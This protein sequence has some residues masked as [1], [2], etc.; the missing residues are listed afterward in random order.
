MN[1]LF[2]W[3][4][5]PQP[6]ARLAAIRI[7]APLAML[8]F[9]SSRLAHPSEWVGDGGFR[10]PQVHDA[11]R[12][13]I[14]TPAL[15]G[16]LATVFA[17]AVVLLALSV[18]FGFHPRKAAVA[19]A[20]ATLFAAL[21]DRL[22]TFTVTK[23]SPALLLA[24]ACT[25]CGAAYSVD[26]WLGRRRD[27]ARSTTGAAS[28]RSAP[29]RFVTR[30]SV[31]FFQSFLCVFYCASGL[32]KVQGD[33]LENPHV[34]WT[35][36]HDTMQTKLTP[37]VANYTPGPMWTVLQASVLAFEVGAPLWFAWRRTR[38]YALVFGLGMH[39]MIGALFWP[40]RWFAMLM[41][42]LLWGAFAPERLLEP[43]RWLARLRLHFPRLPGGPRTAAP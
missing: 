13:P 34:L 16:A 32:C 12:Q 3:L 19:L 9:L 6:F 36:L 35:H 26:A 23:I 30:G 33:W 28:A 25:P 14:F 43:Q 11:V 7:L 1:G 17:V 29:P 15:P 5:Q 8:G 24:L 38:V 40:V 37:I 42:A 4:D 2:R 41:M 18:S 10:L 39:V 22:S 21:G 27:A 20:M 31:F